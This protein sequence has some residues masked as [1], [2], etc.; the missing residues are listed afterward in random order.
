VSERV[1]ECVSECVSDGMTT[2]MLLRE[3]GHVLGAILPTEV[4][5][6]V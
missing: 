3:V 6:N 4:L 1:S 5:S 2:T